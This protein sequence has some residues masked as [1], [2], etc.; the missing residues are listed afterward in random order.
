MVAWRDCECVVAWCGGG[1]GSSR[2]GR[3]TSWAAP[4]GVPLD[5]T[6]LPV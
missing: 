3:G 1:W 6:I 5:H 2:G 4:G